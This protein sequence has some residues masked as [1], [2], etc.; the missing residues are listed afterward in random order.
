[1]SRT[2]RNQEAKYGDV[3][4]SKAMPWSQNSLQYILL[5]VLI[6]EYIIK[7]HFRNQKTIFT[8]SRFPFISRHN[9]PIIA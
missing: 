1:M 4:I 2:R 3:E 5:L 7:V 9:L 8:I 6:I